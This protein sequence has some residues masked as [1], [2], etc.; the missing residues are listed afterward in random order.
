MHSVHGRGEGR[1]DTAL[2]NAHGLLAA[3]DN[4]PNRFFLTVTA[5][6]TAG[7]T[8]TADVV[9]VDVVGVGAAGAQ[10]RRYNSKPRRAC[11]D[12]MVAVGAVAATACRQTTKNGV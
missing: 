5:S 6:C 10:G 8:A 4:K 9:A 2:R 7:V 3:C 1:E 12:D 11:G